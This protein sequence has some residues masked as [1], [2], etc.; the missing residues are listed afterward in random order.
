VI[1]PSIPW[2]TVLAWCALAG[3]LAAQKTTTVA[4]CGVEGP[5][6]PGWVTP[7]PG[8]YSGD[9]HDH[10]QPCGWP[11]GPN[12]GPPIL[13]RMQQSGLNV[14]SVLIWQF[15]AFGSSFVED[16]CLV[17]G[18]EDPLSTPQ[19]VFQSCVETSGLSTSE[20][21][22]L[23]GL[24]LGP[25]EAR[26]ADANQ[27]TGDCYTASNP[28]GLA[29]PGPDGTG[30]TTAPVARFFGTNPQAVRG[31]AHQAWPVAIYHPAGYDWG[32][33]LVSSGFTSDA[34]VLD[35][36]RPLAFPPLDS[37]FGIGQPVLQQ[38][39]HIFPLLAAV[40]A[41]L[42]NV[43]FLE[44]P[45]LEADLR[46]G[47]PTENRWWGMYFR[48][49]SAGVRIG[50]S[51]G[52]DAGCRPTTAQRDLPRTY[53][54]V[55]G[56]LTYD[57][58]CAALARGQVTLSQGNDVFLHMKVDGA[59]V[60]SNVFLPSPAAVDVEVTLVTNGAIQDRIEIV[61][62]GDLVAQRTVVLA[63][64]G[65]KTVHFSSLPI[66]ESTWVCAR[67]CSMTAHTAAVHLFVDDRPI[68]DAASAE[69][70]MIW[71]DAVARTTLAQASLEPFGCQDGDV[72]LDLAQARRAFKS[73]RDADIGFDPSWQVTRIGSST[74]ACRGPIALGV[75]QAVRSG[76][77]FRWTCTNAPPDTDG[78]LYVASGLQANPSGFCDPVTGARVWLDKMKLISPPLPIRSLRSGYAERTDILPPT[79]PGAVFYAQVL[80]PNP[81]G[82]P[83]IGCGTMA[84]YSASDVLRIVVQP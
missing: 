66:P 20:W 32:T 60:G 71:C 1:R 75:A 34:R 49:L 16:V 11:A 29:C 63:R 2:E 46:L 45:D 77:T 84:T 38:Q 59:E 18:S 76:R 58:W 39:R 55:P 74:P 50:P 27:A 35:P 81:P 41:A 48:L 80:W 47:T 19:N 24:G 82:C 43:E 44:A 53:A 36:A 28:M 5:E 65:T 8:W 10:P 54:L 25:A 52:S 42:G 70:W 4:G 13:A 30:Y 51:T 3:L 40:D 72:L 9:T 64:A 57:A 7:L 31:Y 69:Y 73:L 33:E 62:G 12:P 22:H 21:G 79:P 83:G 56:A 14:S 37:L 6:P 15:P 61:A 26:I 68:L 17:T 23:I 78:Q 67:L